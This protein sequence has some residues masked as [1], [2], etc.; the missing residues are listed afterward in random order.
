MNEM[1]WR[2]VRT[3]FSRVGRLTLLY[4]PARFFLLS[5]ALDSSQRGGVTFCSK[6]PGARG[7]DSS[8]YVGYRD[9]VH[10][11][12]RACTRLGYSIDSINI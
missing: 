12:H 5:I 2:G 6:G 8:D 3:F 7:K 10:A 11:T 1:E 9:A 4:Q